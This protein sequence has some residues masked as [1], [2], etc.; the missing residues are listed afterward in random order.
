MKLSPV[1]RVQPS[2]YVPHPARVAYYWW[3]GLRRLKLQLAFCM[4]DQ[5]MGAVIEQE[6]QML[7]NT[8]G[9]Q[10]RT[11]SSRLEEC[12]TILGELIEDLG[13]EMVDQ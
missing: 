2:T 5:Q 11:N 9:V 4:N 7:V 12:A 6:R 8:F 10:M 1:T 3:L 13:L